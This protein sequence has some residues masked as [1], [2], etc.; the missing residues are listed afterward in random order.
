MPAFQKT[1]G[2]EQIFKEIEH[3]STWKLL[4]I[5]EQWPMDK[6]RKRVIQELLKGRNQVNQELADRAEE[7]IRQL[8]VNN[9]S[10]YYRGLLSWYVV[11]SSLDNEDELDN[12]DDETITAAIRAIEFAIAFSEKF[13]EELTVAKEISEKLKK[14]PGLYWQ[15]PSMRNFINKLISGL[16][17]EYSVREWTQAERAIRR[18]ARVEDI[19]YLSWIE[20]LFGSFANG[21][22]KL[23]KHEDDEFTFGQNLQF[24]RDAERILNRAQQEQTP[25][26]NMVVGSYLRKRAGLTGSVIV[27]LEYQQE[28][29]PAKLTVPM[30]IA[31]KLELTD[32]SEASKLASVLKQCSIG[33]YGEGFGG[34][35]I[36]DTGKPVKGYIPPKAQF[37]DRFQCGFSAFPSRGSNRFW[38]SFFDKDKDRDLNNEFAR[39]AR[40]L[41]VG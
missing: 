19:T 38:L 6:V 24:L 32:P 39:V 13:N 4:E 20:K 10:D 27:R 30:K 5:F 12:E 9:D 1:V 23:G 25:D 28:S 29:D 11:D 17:P 3:G 34:V 21:D 15:V 37:N 7:L 40:Y 31:V 33:W 2:L 35:E 16:S 18:I 26:L 22:Y 41:I 8:R 14:A 36:L